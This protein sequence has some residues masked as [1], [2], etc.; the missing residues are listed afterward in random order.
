MIGRNIKRALVRQ[1]KSQR[2]FAKEIGIT[3]TSLS[4]Y[5]KGIRVPKTTVL[6]KIA[7]GL[8]VTADQLL[9]K[10]DTENPYDLLKL[11]VMKY[12]YSSMLDE[13]FCQINGNENRKEFL[14]YARNEINKRIKRL[15]WRAN[16]YNEGSD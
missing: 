14:M 10:D 6:V 8:G 2:T 11:R 3:E 1:G 16:D 9:Q 7:D 15:E 4:R 13:M 12:N 5:I